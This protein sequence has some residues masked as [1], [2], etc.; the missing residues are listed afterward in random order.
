MRMTAVLLAG[1]MVV[2]AGCSDDDGDAVPATSTAIVAGS[3]TTTTTS[4][5]STTTTSI[6]SPS[7]TIDPERF[8]AF[9]TDQMREELATTHV[10]L[11]GWILDADFAWG[12]ELWGRGAVEDPTEWYLAGG[13]MELWISKLVERTA[14]GIPVWNRTDLVVSTYRPD[15]GWALSA[16]CRLG[17][18]RTDGVFAWY[19]T[20][21]G[22]Q[23]W[24]PAAEAWRVDF[25]TGRAAPINA[26][27]VDCENA[28]FGL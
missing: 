11:G 14:D 10:D 20:D 26:G 1:A 12:V 21:G 28:T 6:P 13:E 18:D 15:D 7:S 17:G 5:T 2:A 3:S 8:A 9:T 16:N 4:A 27:V 24:I 19:P 25:E 22:V 23:E